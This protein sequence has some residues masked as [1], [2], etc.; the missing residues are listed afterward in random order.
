VRIDRTARAKSPKTLSAM[1][2]LLDFNETFVGDCQDET[3]QNL[4]RSAG[5]SFNGVEIF[6]DLFWG[7]GNSRLSGCRKFV[8]IG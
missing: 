7:R 1:L 8:A 2:R 4:L 5:R 6:E 3:A